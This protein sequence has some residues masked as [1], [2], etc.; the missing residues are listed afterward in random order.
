MKG[1]AVPEVGIEVCLPDFRRRKNETSTEDMAVPTSG[2]NIVRST[3][4]S[5]VHI[6]D[7]IR[8]I[9]WNPYYRLLLL[10]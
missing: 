2:F 1:A 3:I 7:G 9:L 8:V 10:P 5:V 6:R 4:C